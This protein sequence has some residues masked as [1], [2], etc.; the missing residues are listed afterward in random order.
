MK[1]IFSMLLWLCILLW[2]NTATAQI[3]VGTII[4]GTPMLTMTNAQLTDTFA[5]I[6]NNATLSNSTVESATDSLGQL[7]YIKCAGTRS[8][9]DNP[10]KIAIILSVNGNNLVFDNSNGCTME[11]TA[12]LPCQTCDQVIFERCARQR[13]SCQSPSGGCNSSIS[14]PNR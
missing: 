2:N 11:C 6:L 9:Q 8:N 13:C 14:F 4:D 3:A 10:S 7:F 12:S 5:Y 1:N